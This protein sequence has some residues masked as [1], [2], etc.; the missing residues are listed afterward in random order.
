MD[1][2]F[3]QKA[4]TA[5]FWT[6]TARFGA[7]LFSW[8]STF[9]VIRYINS[10][11]YGIIS[12]AEISFSL[13]VLISSNGLA[14]SLIQAKELSKNQI[15]NLLG[16]YILIC[17]ILFMVHISI[18]RPLTE[19]FSEPALFEVLIALSFTFLLIPW[20]ALPSALLSREMDFKKKSIADLIASI[21]S[22]AIALTMAINNFQ[23]WALV[24]SMIFM[25]VYQAV[26]YCVIAKFIVVPSFQFTNIKH[27]IAFGSI[28]TLTSIIWS[29]YTK[30]DLLIAGRFLTT[31][32]I[33]IFAVAASLAMLP[34]T[35][36]I[37]II[38]QVAFPLYSKKQQNQHE[39]KYYFL[40]SQRLGGIISFPI[41]FG[42]AATGYYTLPLILG[43]KWSD[44]ALPFTL[45]C[46]VVPLRFS[47]NLFSPATKGIGKPK[48]NLLNTIIMI[49]SLSIGVIVFI[50]YGILGLVL[51]W[52]VVT[53]IQFIFCTNISCKALNISF[54]EFLQN[55][56]PGFLASTI[57]AILVLLFYFKTYGWLSDFQIFMAAIII[58]AI[59]YLTLLSLF[60]KETLKELTSFIRTS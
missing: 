21:L 52:L 29:L 8:A 51:A 43:D 49:T 13:F 37:P 38:G 48:V 45:L 25:F 42:M 53:P 2:T 47:M 41:F 33:G 5:L 39:I 4:K 22:A 57:M 15:R 55:L 56:L 54:K 1:K 44:T 17:A 12:L 23:H 26:S 30:V 3:T 59:T 9:L 46:L 31:E 18:A 40:K 24:T 50:D 27:F 14:E 7:Q 19:Y 20:I 11:A 10:T 28:I 36:L 6:A 32:Q 34:M 35:K 16:F 60:F 58:G